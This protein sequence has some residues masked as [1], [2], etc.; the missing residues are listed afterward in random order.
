MRISK[1]KSSME[2]NAMTRLVKVCSLPGVS[3]PFHFILLT[4]SYQTIAKHQNKIPHCVKEIPPPSQ[5][6]PNLI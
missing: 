4:L 6:L 2:S 5:R 1:I 3:K